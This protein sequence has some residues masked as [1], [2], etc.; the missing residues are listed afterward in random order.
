MIAAA[1]P[2]RPRAGGR[3]PVRRAARPGAGAAGGIAATGGATRPAPGL[4]VRRARPADARAI[5][6]VMRASIRTLARGAL[7]ARQIAAWSS[8]PPLYHLW[9]MTAGG[10]RYLVAEQAGRMAGYGA[11]RGGELTAVFVRPREARRGVGTALVSALERAA[12]RG[13]AR[14]MT[15]LA[16]PPALAF[17]AALGFRGTR[18]VRVPLPGGVALE[19]RALRKSL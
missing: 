1:N 16:A 7:P 8:L 11:L 9:A 6:A 4:R 2:T 3:T 10:E 14:T 18:A 19:A 15:V 17:Y 12:R 5:A 13:G